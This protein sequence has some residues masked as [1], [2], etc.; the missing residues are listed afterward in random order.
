MDSKKE[1]MYKVEFTEDFVEELN[2][3]YEYISQKLYA[4]KAAIDLLTKTIDKIFELE[5]YP[6]MYMKLK[7]IDKLK[8]I[9]HRMVVNNYV[10]LYTI[11]YENNKVYISH[12]V[13]GKSNYLK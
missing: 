9:Y 8:N 13:Y 3:I 11:D 2:E 4:N 7:K 10:V 1:K 12:I 5:T 6:E